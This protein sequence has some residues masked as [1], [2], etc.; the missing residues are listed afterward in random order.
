MKPPEQCLLCGSPSSTEAAAKC[1]ACGWERAFGGVAGAGPHSPAE[2]S[3][4]EAARSL[5][6]NLEETSYWFRHRSAIIRAVVRRFSPDGPIFDVG[7]GNGY[8]AADLQAAGHDVVLVEPGAEGCRAARE[9]GV[10]RVLGDTLQGLML[11]P[12]RV[13]AVSLFDVLEHVQDPGLLLREVFRVLEP[14][15]RV[16]ITVP[17]HA[18]LW[19]M[20][21]DDALHY[22]RYTIRSLA[23]EVLAAGLLVEYSTYFFL[24]LVLPIA[25][26]RSLPYR[27]GRA[28]PGES[29]QSGRASR[30]HG[31]GNRAAEWMARLLAW[32]ARVV[33]R[34]RIPYG[35][36]VLLVATRRMAAEASTP[37]VQVHVPTPVRP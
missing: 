14:G 27:V 22:R 19:S 4:P 29:L 20:A 31:A 13:A 25:L 7:G 18:W 34:G 16:Y 23:Q 8:Q 17:A 9:R 35:A 36:S 6:L 12:G 2:L 3:Y 10:R 24:A 26:M 15:G 1:E 32:E 30:E 37:P 11:P 28:T 21:D 5:L 33:E